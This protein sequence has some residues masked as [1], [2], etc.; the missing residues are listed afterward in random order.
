MLSNLD[1]ILFSW[2][3]LNLFLIGY[4]PLMFSLCLAVINLF[5]TIVV[6][7]SIALSSLYPSCLEYNIHTHIYIC[8]CVYIK[9]FLYQRRM[10][11]LT[12]F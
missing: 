7:T 12:F 9:V 11:P 10:K 8:V 1:M 4:L 2:F 3:Y 6:V 5:L